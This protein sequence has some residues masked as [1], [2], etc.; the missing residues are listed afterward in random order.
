MEHLFCEARL[1]I[2]KHI[3]IYIYN[4]HLYKCFSSSLGALDGSADVSSFRALGPKNSSFLVKTLHRCAQEPLGRSKTLRKHCTG[5]LG[6]H[7]NGR[8]GNIRECFR[9]ARLL[10]DSATLHSVRF[11]LRMDILRSTLIYI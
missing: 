4:I 7:F 6:S 5:L 3:Y 10:R 9:G 2:H 11:T 8:S 1:G